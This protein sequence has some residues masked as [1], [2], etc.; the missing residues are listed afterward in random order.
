MIDVNKGKA[1]YSTYNSNEPFPHI[2]IDNFLPEGIVRSVYDSL[3]QTEKWGFDELEWLQPYQQHKWQLDDNEGLYVPNRTKDIIKFLNSPITLNFLTSLTGI[4]NLIPDEETSGGGV[5]KITKGGKLN[6][7]TDYGRHPLHSDLYRRINLL[8]YINP[9]WDESW[10]GKL[11]FKKEPV[12]ESQ[13]VITPLFNR[14]VI[15][16]TTDISYHGHPEPL[17]CPENEARYSLAMYYF[18]K[19]IPDYKVKEFVNFY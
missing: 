7:H 3:V 1:L 8:L 6:I 9:N 10:G 2:V 5:H 4:S 18:T 14:A 16:N 12:G 17:N 19:E 11:H 15:F 13:V